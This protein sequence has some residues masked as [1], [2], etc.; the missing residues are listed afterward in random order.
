M[1]VDLDMD[2]YMKAA[3]DIPWG[4]QWVWIQFGWKIFSYGSRGYGPYRRG[5]KISQMERCAVTYATSQ[6]NQSLIKRVA[7]NAGYEKVV[8]LYEEFVQLPSFQ[9]CTQICHFRRFMVC[10]KRLMASKRIAG[11]GWTNNFSVGTYAF[12]KRIRYIFRISESSIDAWSALVRRFVHTKFNGSF[13]FTDINWFQDTSWSSS[14]NNCSWGKFTTGF[15]A[16]HS[17]KS[18]YSVF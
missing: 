16:F 5:S 15:V 7:P 14:W 11:D 10:D 2:G 12:M 9:S 8:G 18:F 17:S 1:D 3:R 4:L 13:I 6:T